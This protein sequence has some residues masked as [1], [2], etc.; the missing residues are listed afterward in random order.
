MFP[1]KSINRTETQNV[2]SDKYFSQ[3]FSLLHYKNNNFNILV[4]FKSYFKV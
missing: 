4:K 3:Q 1:S 2:D